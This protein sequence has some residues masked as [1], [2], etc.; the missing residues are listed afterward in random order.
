MGSSTLLIHFLSPLASLSSR[1]DYLLLEMGF[2]ALFLPRVEFVLHSLS[3][4]SA[5]L[6]LM[7][8]YLRWLLFRLMFGFGKMKFH[9]ASLREFS[10]LKGFM[11]NQPLP[12]V[13]GWWLHS[14]PL[15]VHVFGLLAFFLSEIIIP[16]GFTF[17]RG[18]T[19]VLCAWATVFLQGNIGATGNFG[20]FQ[21][22]SV[23]LCVSAMDGRSVFLEDF[24]SS[25]ILSSPL[26]HLI[27]G[28]ILMPLT[29]F[30]LVFNSWAT[31]SFMHWPSLNL[32]STPVGRF[33]RLLSPF[34]V[35]HAYGIFFAH[36]SPAVRWVPVL[37]GSEEEVEITGRKEEDEQRQ[38]AVKWTPYIYRFMTVSPFR[39]PPFKAP[40]H[41]RF[42]Q[43]I[44][45]DSLGMMPDTLMASVSSGNPYDFR[46]EGGTNLER[47]AQ[48]LLLDQQDAEEGQEG[49]PV[50]QLFERNPFPSGS[51]PVRSLRITL[52][53]YRATTPSEMLQTG[54]YWTVKVAGNQVGGVMTRR[55]L[56]ES[57]VAPGND[58]L[59][60]SGATSS[61]KASDAHPTSGPYFLLRDPSMWHPDHYLWQTETTVY[62]DMMH[63]WDAPGRKLEKVVTVRME[64]FTKS[65]SGGANPSSLYER[66]WNEFLPR[67]RQVHQHLLAT[68]DAV[69]DTPT[70]ASGCLSCRLESTFLADPTRA[71]RFQRPILD[72][73]A[74][75]TRLRGELVH[76]AGVAS[77]STLPA[78]TPS[79]FFFFQLLTHRLSLLLTSRILSAAAEADQD[80]LRLPRPGDP[81][82]KSNVA[83]E[84]QEKLDTE[85]HSAATAACKAHRSSLHL[86]APTLG[87]NFGLFNEKARGE[88]DEAAEGGQLRLPS[89]YHLH[90][91]TTHVLLS[92]STEA[93]F[94]DVCRDPH[95]KASKFVETFHVAT[96]MLTTGVFSL[97]LLRFH[98]SKCRLT[99]CITFPEQREH[100]GLLPGF[101]AVFFHFLPWQFAKRGGEEVET[102]ALPKGVRRPERW[103][104]VWEVDWENMSEP[105]VDLTWADPK[106]V[107][108]TR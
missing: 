64:S 25:Q 81:S 16:F 3:L 55:S 33:L 21:A 15:P 14:M 24:H 30:Y 108:A 94:L 47:V 40:F 98:S 39:R 20:F 105:Q 32:P 102:P 60:Q 28:L 10:Y 71:S 73:S 57:N 79:D 17:S 59:V 7:T 65:V 4:T 107:A 87:K 27:F 38:K 104:E 8:L 83:E 58:K 66:L 77:S 80:C 45:Y 90:L 96:G 86:P 35:I 99:R 100:S 76:T 85:R 56:R 106:P 29:L 70:G 69:K 19:R 51:K 67:V 36:S 31:M 91:F 97:A 23:V 75:V 93:E 61:A 53:L 5:P 6:P 49:S 43:A 62:R 12:T 74:E 18:T 46:G 11:I 101:L 63:A 89:F 41:F 84:A 42:D 37:E 1:W 95:G 48:C 68:I 82:R 54:R 9:G 26:T 22:A 92:C 2:C 72:W 88:M 78:F 103:N 50:E 44:V 52:Y 13:V 34:H